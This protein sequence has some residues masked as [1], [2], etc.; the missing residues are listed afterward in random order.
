MDSAKN[1]LQQLSQDPAA[2]RLARD[3]ADG[4]K[5]YKMDLAASRREGVN[6]GR[7]EGVKAGREEG[8][9]A[10]LRASVA[11]A[12]PGAGGDSSPQNA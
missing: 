12:E 6:A 9:A 5:F 11:L 8:V 7:E 4:A 1:A 2:A 10:T 3:R